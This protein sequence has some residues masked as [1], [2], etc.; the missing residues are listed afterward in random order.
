M[1][2]SRGTKGRNNNTNNG[3]SSMSA[4]ERKLIQSVKEIVD[5]PENEIYATLKE[6]NMDPDEAAYRLLNQDHFHEV[7]SKREKKK[8]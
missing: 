7:K 5:F 6:C 1:S 8:E 3:S 4:E 2:T